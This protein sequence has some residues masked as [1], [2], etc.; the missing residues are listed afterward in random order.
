[1]KTASQLKIIKYFMAFLNWIYTLYF[2]LTN[3]TYKIISNPNGVILCSVHEMRQW[4]PLPP[5]HWRVYLGPGLGQPLVLPRPGQPIRGQY[6]EILTNH[7]SPG[8]L[9]QLLVAPPHQVHPVQR[10]QEGEPRP[11]QVPGH[12]LHLQHTTVSV[13]SSA[14]ANDP[15]VFTI[16]DKAPNGG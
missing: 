3:I 14:A 5:S 11:R 2:L 6:G 8:E 7:S 15:S 1:M 10:Q 9:L 16:M 12:A 13:I 4:R